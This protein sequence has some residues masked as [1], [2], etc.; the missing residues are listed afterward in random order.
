MWHEERLLVGGELVPAEGNRTYPTIDP[1]TGEPLGE[2]A[3]A[4]VGD[5]RRAVESARKAFDT[6][7]WATDQAFRAACLRQLHD[8]LIANQ[9]DLRSLLIADNGLPFMLTQ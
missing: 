4:S 6:T 7:T 1:T 2:A 5:A 8:A 3:D 9:E